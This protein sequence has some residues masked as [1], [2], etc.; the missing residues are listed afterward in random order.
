M[1]AQRT[2]GRRL[3]ITHYSRV[4]TSGGDS[5]TACGLNAS[6]RVLADTVKLGEVTC[7]LCLRRLVQKIG[8]GNQA[9]PKN[10]VSTRRSARAEND[11]AK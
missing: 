9:A 3:N 10:S 8:S 11:G 5:F 2:G 1:P 6:V 7:K 4:Y